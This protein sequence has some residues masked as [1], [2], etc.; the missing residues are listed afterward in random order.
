M[1]GVAVAVI[2]PAVVAVP[3]PVEDGGP[4]QDEAEGQRG[5]VDGQHFGTSLRRLRGR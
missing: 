5:E 2:V 1:V 3:V 4:D